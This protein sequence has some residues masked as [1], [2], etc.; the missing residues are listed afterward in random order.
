MLLENEWGK[1]GG[2]FKCNVSSFLSCLGFILLLTEV[3]HDDFGIPKN[4]NK[5]IA[6]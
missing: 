4:I 2:L 1:S 5:K 6:S 3:A